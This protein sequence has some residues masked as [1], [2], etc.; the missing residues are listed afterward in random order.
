MKGFKKKDMV[1]NFCEKIAENVD[2][3]GD[4]NFIEEVLK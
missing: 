4:S 1:E 2:F 3:V